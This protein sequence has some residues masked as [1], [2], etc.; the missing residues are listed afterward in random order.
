MKLKV[1]IMIFNAVLLTIFFTVFSFSFFTAGTQFIGTFFKNYWIFI[2]SFFCFLLAINIFFFFNWKLITTLEA[3]DWPALSL[4]LE[5][6]IFKKHHITTK[7]VRLL[8]EISILLGDFKT[9]QQLETLLEEQKP[10]YIRRFA[11]RFA[12]VRLLAGDYQG[13]EEFSAKMSGLKRI[14]P[15]MHFY[16]AFSKQMLKRYP[17]AAEQF[18][19]IAQ[20]ERDPLIR[21]LST[22]FM[23]CGL[24]RYLDIDR[25]EVEKMINT[26]KNVLK[27]RP[28]SY[29]RKYSSKEKQSIHILVLTKAIDEA[30]LWLFKEDPS[31]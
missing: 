2:V 12:A 17:E 11:T 25:A 29:W 26:E 30:L 3:E 21:L 14:S 20:T 4:Y 22:Y 6:E 19:V 28:L 24:A 13:L 18:A 10:R 9:L 7:K 8:C 27:K 16:Y 23:A 31:V 15:W 5:E 1:L